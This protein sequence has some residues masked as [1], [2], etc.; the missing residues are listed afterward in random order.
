MIVLDMISCRTL[1]FCNVI[2]SLRRN[3]CWIRQYSGQSRTTFES[4][5]RPVNIASWFPGHMYRGMMQLQAKLAVVDC[6]IEVHDARIPFTGRNPKLYTMLSAIKPHILVLNKRDLAES[7]FEEGV[8]R[9]LARE[10]IKNVIYT[11]CKESK[12]GIQKVIPLA[13]DL[14]KDSAL[15]NRGNRSSFSVMIVGIPNVG[16]SSLINRLRNYHL[17]KKNASAVGAL[18]GIT[19]SVLERIKVSQNPDIYLFDSPGIMQPKVENLEVGLKLALCRTLKDSV[20]G[21][22]LIA[23]YLLYWLNKHKKLRYVEYLNLKEPTDN[24]HLLLIHIAK[25]LNK[26]KKVNNAQG[27]LITVPDFEE[28]SFYFVNSF[29]EGK[30]GKIFLDMEYLPKVK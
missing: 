19:K 14:I 16:K 20:V 24:I 10:N 9:Q 11:N 22:E 26:V 18:P 5:C 12:Q 27:S 17:H 13:V 1:L 23:D 28:S 7:S 4:K 30:F 29:R 15:Y 6:V 3:S 21:L 8:K 2:R 25:E